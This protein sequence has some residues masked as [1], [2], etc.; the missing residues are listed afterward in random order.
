M[1][2]FQVGDKVID[3]MRFEGSHPIIRITEENTYP[4]DVY[5]NG[6]IHSYL[7]DGRNVGTHI[8]PSLYH[9][10]TKITIEEA[11]PVRPKWVNVY[12]N[13]FRTWTGFVYDSMA[14]AIEL[15]KD[16]PFYIKTIELKKE[17]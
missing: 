6:V 2:K 8:M 7:R 4:I 10:G 11:E 1:S 16:A 12:F 13:G 5:V 17:G 14:E 3:P 9:A 15:P